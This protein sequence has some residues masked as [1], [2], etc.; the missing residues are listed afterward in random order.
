MLRLLSG[1][2]I[3]RL[4][5]LSLACLLASTSLLGAQG[6]SG[7]I[8]GTLKDAQGGVLPGVSLTLRNAE[9]GVMRTAVSEG[10]GTYRLAGLLPG[11][12][13]LAAELSGFSTSEIKDIA[14]LM[15]ATSRSEQRH[16]R[17]P[18]A[19]SRRSGRTA[20]TGECVR[21]GV[22][23]ARENDCDRRDDQHGQ[24]VLHERAGLRRAVCERNGERDGVV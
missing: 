2:W 22:D 19:P 24:R 9:S 16:L 8:A 4:T 6:T 12:Y 23:R 18:A 15:G 3:F 13:E 1:Q 11:R 14:N 21:N 7:V 5:L 20:G 17:Q 10:D